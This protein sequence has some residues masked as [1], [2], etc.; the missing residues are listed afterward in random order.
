MTLTVPA[1]LVADARRGRV[2]DHDFVEC[3]RASLPYAYDMVARLAGELSTT[4]RTFVDNQEEPPTETAR[5]QLLRAMSS[6]AIRA[7][8]E[9][10]FNIVL[11]FQ[12]S[13]RVGVFPPNA[14]NRPEYREFTSIEGQVLNERRALL[15]W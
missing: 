8:L 6:N 13:H 1:S 10:H 11:A 15:S 4:D 5:E 3:V 12:N 7:G 14:R 9:R 2:L